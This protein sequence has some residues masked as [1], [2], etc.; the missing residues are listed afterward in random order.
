MTL[1]CAFQE[2]CI[3]MFFIN[4]HDETLKVWDMRLRSH[5]AVCIQTATGF[6]LLPL[7]Q[8][9]DTCLV[10]RTVLRQ[11]MD[12]QVTI[13]WNDGSSTL[14]SFLPD[15][16][17]LHLLYMVGIAT[18]LIPFFGVSFN[19]KPFCTAGDAIPNGE[20]DGTLVFIPS[21][22]KEK[23][24]EISPTAPWTDFLEGYEIQ[25]ED[26]RAPKRRFASSSS[27]PLVCLVVTTPSGLTADYECIRDRSLD[28]FL[29][30]IGF[31][32]ED[33]AS[34]TV[35]CGEQVLSF[36]EPMSNLHNTHIVIDTHTVRPQQVDPSRITIEVIKP[37][38]ITCFLECERS[39]SIHQCL[40]DA[41][42][43]ETWVDQVRASMQGR[44]IPLT[45][46]C[47]EVGHNPVR[48]RFF[49][50]KGGTKG[51]SKGKGKDPLQVQD[52]WAKSSNAPPRSSIRWDQLVLPSDHPF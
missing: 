35:K 37:N 17:V 8:Y 25:D 12:I 28:Q 47:S 2:A 21:A 50:L 43:P 18:H 39:Q 31:V 33:F 38:G 52:P 44:L 36:Q 30:T 46:L 14:L 40:L 5:N 29:R 23:I 11:Y 15:S 19:G 10:K 6:A 42:F 16:K 41:A 49:P 51:G 45:M 22:F 24:R 48:L 4:I 27:A 32:E 1:L 7:Q 9:V 34:L 3:G 13:R 26:E 20:S